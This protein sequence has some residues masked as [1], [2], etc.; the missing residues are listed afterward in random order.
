MKKLRIMS[1][2]ALAIT[3]FISM[4]MLFNLLGSM[5]PSM[6]DGIGVH[7]ILWGNLYF[8]D[9]NWSHERFYD[10]FVISSFISFTVF[11]ENIVLAILAIVK[12]K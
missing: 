5:I 3:S 9:R 6:N 2:I 7:S 4:D 11:I 8:G 10:A 1:L 12:K